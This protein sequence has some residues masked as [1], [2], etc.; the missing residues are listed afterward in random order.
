MGIIRARLAGVALAAWLG[1]PLALSAA[2][3]PITGTLDF[4]A[5]DLGGGVY[6]GT[7]LGTQFS[8]SIDDTTFSGEITDGNTT[9]SFGCCIAAGGLEIFDDV[10]LDADTAAILNQLSGTSQFEAGQVYDSVNVE[11]DAATL[12]GGRIEVGVSYLLDAGAFADT[13]PGNYPFDPADLRAAWFFILEE[14]YDG[15]DIYEGLG[16]L[17]SVPEPALAALLAIAA[18]VLGGARPISR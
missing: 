9:I 15:L 1:A 2:T 18:L 7:A 4:V 10:T 11:G 6:S 8:G 12:G 3:I 16:A 17:Q 13:S 14:E 5:T